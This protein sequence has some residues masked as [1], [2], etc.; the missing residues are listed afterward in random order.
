MRTNSN[1]N[2]EKKKM[3]KKTIEKHKSFY[4]LIYT[5]FSIEFIKINE[6]NLYTE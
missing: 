6:Y 5:K 4:Y 3:G 1:S 2:T